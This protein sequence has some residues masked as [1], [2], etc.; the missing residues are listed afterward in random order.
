MY[1]TGEFLWLEVTCLEGPCGELV[2]AGTGLGSRALPTGSGL[3]GPAGGLSLAGGIPR[4]RDHNRGFGAKLVPV[5]SAG[6][7]P[8]GPAAVLPGW[9]SE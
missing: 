9:L 8:E 7:S 6:P 3:T 5:R 2:R 4:D 1:T